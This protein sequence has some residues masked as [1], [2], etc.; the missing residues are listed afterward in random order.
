MTSEAIV[1]EAVV[2]AFILICCTALTSL[3]G[4]RFG[5]VGG[6]GHTAMCPPPRSVAGAEGRGV[7]Q[8]RVLCL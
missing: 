6:T 5:R 3:A 8:I 2:K 1:A 7:L 4:G